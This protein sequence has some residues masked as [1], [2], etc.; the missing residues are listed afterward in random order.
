MRDALPFLSV[1]PEIGLPALASEAGQAALALQFQLHRTQWWS[2]ETLAHH[3]F[4]QLR[5]LVAHA[6]AQ[7]PYYRDHL[8]RANIFTLAGLSPASFPRWPILRRAD[9]QANA[10]ALLARNVPAGHGPVFWGQTTG[11]TG[12]PVR[13]AGTAAGRLFQEACIL[14][15]QFWYGLDVTGKFAAI[16]PGANEAAFTDWGPPASTVF[17]TGPACSYSITRDPADQLAWLCAQDPDYLI[18]LGHNLRSLIE[19]SRRSGR[20]PVRLKALLS[21][22]DRPPEDLATLARAEWNV[23]VHDTY[24]ASEFGTL[25]LQCPEHGALHIQSESVFVEILRDDGTACAPGETGRVIVT[26]LH[27]F[28]MP[29]IRYDVGDYAEA[30]GPCACGRGL[31]TLA[32]IAG[33]ATAMA[34]D[35]TGR[36]YWPLL[37]PKFWDDSGI[38]QRQL[39]QKTPSRIEVRYVAPADLDDARRAMVAA[40]LTRTLRY[41]YDYDF[42]RVDA[43]ARTPGGKFEE[44]V[45]EIA[46]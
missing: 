33:R 38:T 1:I 28:A 32:R 27:N 19:E 44:F 23:P 35:P 34:V 11:S 39:I 7:V 21:F 4:R 13:F 12:E 40:G 3:Q 26:D 45:S 25:A 6:L 20:K 10:Q 30:G 16:R 36:R 22:A 43:I 9:L 14:R 8:R 2:T 29:L 41:A 46:R 24:S 5:E 42:V 17:A 18:S 15:S 37:S 31:P